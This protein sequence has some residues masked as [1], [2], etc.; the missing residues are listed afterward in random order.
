MNIV[1]AYVGED[2]WRLF[3]VSTV[4]TVWKANNGDI[5]R[6]I[7]SQVSIH[8]SLGKKDGYGFLPRVVSKYERVQY[9]QKHIPKQGR[10]D[11]SHE[12]H[13]QVN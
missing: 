7:V 5:L 11:T 9:L 1:W 3:R 2:Y 4:Y 13:S 6:L 8:N 10:T 12:T